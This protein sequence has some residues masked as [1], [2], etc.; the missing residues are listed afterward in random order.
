MS[1]TPPANEYTLRGALIVGLLG[2]VAI[3]PALFVAPWL[4]PI[5]LGPT[6]AGPIITSVGQFLA[7]L[8]AGVVIGPVVTVG[9]LLGLRAVLCVARIVNG[10]PGPKKSGRPALADRRGPR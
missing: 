1:G 9:L 8:L 10:R 5:L 7:V 2:G 4:A 3:A 6:N